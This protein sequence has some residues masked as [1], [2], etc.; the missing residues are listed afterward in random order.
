MATTSDFKRRSVLARRLTAGK[1]VLGEVNEAGIAVNFGDAAAEASFAQ[2]LGLA[3]LSPWPRCGFKGSGSSSWLAGQGLDLPAESNRARRQA[4]GELVARLAPEELLILCDPR[5]EPSGLAAS[6][7]AAWAAESLPPEAPRGYPVPRQDSHFWF[8]LTGE[9]TPALFAKICA[10]DLRPDKFPN[11]T[12][13]QT[14]VARLSAI[15]IRDDRGDTLGFH[16][17][18]DS[19]SAEFLVDAVFDAMSEFD[20]RA[21]GLEALRALG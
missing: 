8:C 2:M 11:L 6:L 10:I 9:W 19:A 12:I 7:P 16:L 14:S 18:A 1:A 13:A 17:L 21:M 5:Q 3:D 15:V 20:G 4:G